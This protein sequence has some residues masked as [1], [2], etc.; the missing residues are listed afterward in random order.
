VTRSLGSR[1]Q[2]GDIVL[3][4]GAVG[5]ELD[6]RGV[7]TR[8]PLWSALGLTDAP[9][10]VR[11]IHTDYVAAGADVLIAN[12]FRTTRRT[13]AKEPE[14]VVDLG[15]LNTLAIDLAREAS[16]SADR[17]VLV[18]G[19]IAP[20][21]DCYSPWLSP[22][23]EI[24]LA[25]HREQ[26]RWLAEAGADLLM[27]ETMPSAAEAEAAVIAA[28]ETGLDVTAGFVI[29]SDGRLLSGETL[30]EAVPRVERH[31]VVAIL[32]NCAPAVE[33]GRA[34]TDLTAL[35]SLPCGGYANLGVVDPAV[36]WSSDQSVGGSAYADAVR[37]WIERGARLVGGCCGTRPEHIAAVRRMLDERNEPAG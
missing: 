34:I 20:L 26:A 17:D 13:F 16:A 29:G 14:V 35:T 31:G 18:A 1:L 21:E 28:T 9:D 15:A 4:D 7:A 3:L 37:D 30:T 32:I 24:A 10:I 23:F 5:T 27:V 33:I 25:E 36:G 8:L 22:S 2:T 11:A 19:S 6:R 12:T